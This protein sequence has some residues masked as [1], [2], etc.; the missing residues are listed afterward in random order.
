MASV[1]TLVRRLRFSMVV[2]LRKTD[3]MDERVMPSVK[4]PKKPP[5]EGISYALELGNALD[6]QSQCKDPMNV[7]LIVLEGRIISLVGNKY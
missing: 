3:C 4:R 1:Q 5:L 6:L 2:V 7:E